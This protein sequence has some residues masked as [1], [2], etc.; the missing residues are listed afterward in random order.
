MRIRKRVAKVALTK[1][2]DYLKVLLI[3]DSLLSILGGGTRVLLL[4]L[5]FFWRGALWWCGARLVVVVG[6]AAKI[7]QKEVT[8]E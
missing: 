2:R 3:R 6:R 5:D 4:A 7:A 1:E 8:V